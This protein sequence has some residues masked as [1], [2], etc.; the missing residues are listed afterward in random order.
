MN[1]SEYLIVISPPNTIINYVADL[2]IGFKKENGSYRSVHSKAHITLTN[3]L[4]TDVEA[5][6]LLDRLV[7]VL[8][9]FQAFD[10]YLNGYDFFDSNETFFI[11][12][13][14]NECLQ[15]LRTL[16]L[17]QVEYVIPS[18]RSRSTSYI[19]HITIGK[20]LSKPQFFHAYHLFK[21]KKYLNYFW[22]E[23]ITVLKRS[24]KSDYQIVKYLPLNTNWPYVTYTMS[25]Y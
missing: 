15:H 14:E 9:D 4:L 5:K 18:L 17:E 19:P 22:T 24:E 10:I 7:K 13:E 2:K 11:K 3:I 25:A 16:V 21:K 12:I 23:D 6:H 1:R 8:S 20:Q